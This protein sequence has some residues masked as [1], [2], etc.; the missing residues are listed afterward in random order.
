VAGLPRDWSEIGGGVLNGTNAIWEDRIDTEGPYWL[1]KQKHANISQGYSDG[2]AAS[3]PRSPFKDYGYGPKV[4]PAPDQIGDG[5]GIASWRSSLTG[6]DP[7]EPAQLSVP[8]PSDRPI[9]YLS[10]WTQ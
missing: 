9:R 6:V 10:R 8:A 5:N 7:Q 4:Q 3:E 1:S 2:L